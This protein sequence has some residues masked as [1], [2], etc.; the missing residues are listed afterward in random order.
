MHLSNFLPVGLMLLIAACHAGPAAKPLADGCY[1]AKGKPV[2]EISGT[3][4]RVL[5][6]GEVE[7]FKVDRS[8]AAVRFTP[9]L[10]FDGTDKAP[11]LV[12]ADQGTRTYSMNVGSSV[13]TIQMHW[14]AYG[15]ED[16]YL[17]KPCSVRAP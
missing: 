8:G 4:G 1:Y 17:G 14:A 15:D 13:P 12:D 2:F 7:N 5:I 6:P 16:V 9:G 3:E 10:L 11:S